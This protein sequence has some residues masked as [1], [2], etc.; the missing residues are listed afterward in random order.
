MKEDLE[1][2]RE[3]D[4]FVKDMVQRIAR[5][6]LYPGE[7]LPTENKLAE[8]YGIS[9]TNVHLGIKELA[10]L[11]FLK[12][13]PRHATYVVD[14]WDN[15]TL[16]SLSTVI[17][18]TDGAP[19]RATVNAFI[20]LREMLGGGLIRWMAASASPAYLR[21][22]DVCCDELERTAALLPAEEKAFRAALCSFLHQAY[23]KARNPVFP[24]L[25][26]SARY[27]VKRAFSV[28]YGLI[29]PDELVRVYRSVLRLVSQDKPLEAIA[30][31]QDWNAR[32]IQRYLQETFEEA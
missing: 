15:V 18:Y 8:E 29:D 28:L 10:R 16:E 1:N 4:L 3:Q 21:A 11:G 6:E 26:R 20:A 2:V 14:S 25:I 17:R 13:V 23:M 30:V 32:L 9:K 7:R 22:L 27:V 24:V 12:I 31:W 5:D 19:E